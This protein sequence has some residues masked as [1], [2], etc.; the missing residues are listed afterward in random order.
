LI[1]QRAFFVILQQTLSALMKELVLLYLLITTWLLPNYVAPDPIRLQ[2]ERMPFTPKEFYVSQ[3]TDQRSGQ[4]RGP[5]AQLALAVGQPVQ[6]VD[7]AGGL[8]AGVRQ[9]VQQSL[10]QNR[11]LRPVAMRL[12]QCKVVETIAGNRV[13][14]QFTFAVSFD[15]LAQDGTATQLTEYR[16][17]TNYVRPVGQTTVVESSIRQALVAS[18]R[19]LNSYMDREAGNNEKLATAINISFTEDTRLTDNDTV[20][21]NPMRKLV[22]NDFLAVP[23]RG[24]H[25]AAEVFTSFSYEGKSSVKDGVVQLNLQLKGYMLKNSSW[26]RPEA[27]NEYALNHEQRHFDITKLVMERFK[28]KIQPDSLTVEDY[29][30]IVQY[31]FL[32]SYREMNRLQE[33]YDRETNHGI[34]QGLQAIWNNRIDEELQTLGVKN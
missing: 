11:S 24:S 17:G 10:P 12:R 9:F 32:E 16:G 7:L 1:F 8:E 13:T 21:Y 23:R 19:S 31:Q 29:N 4:D 20:F 33:Q 26:A 28:Q 5:F 27:R 30:S 14:G 34:N 2:P 18:L 15:L 25:Y 6:R 3:V 22:W